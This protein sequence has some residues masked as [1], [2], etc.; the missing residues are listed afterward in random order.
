MYIANKY[1]LYDDS[2]GNVDF[3][4]LVNWDYRSRLPIIVLMKDVGEWEI[5]SKTVPA[6]EV[7]RHVLSH[8]F[9]KDGQQTSRDRLTY[10]KTSKEVPGNHVG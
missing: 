10:S 5:M 6:Y 1:I 4:L 7:D 3:V 2:S 9:L 8:L